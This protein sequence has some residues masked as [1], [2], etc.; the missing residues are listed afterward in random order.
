MENNKLDPLEEVINTILKSQAQTCVLAKK[1]LQERTTKKSC[2]L[3]WQAK[4]NK[5]L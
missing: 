5:N 3:S 4:N 1:K 2:D